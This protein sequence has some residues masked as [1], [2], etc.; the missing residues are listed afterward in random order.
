MPT[1]RWEIFSGNVFLALRYSEEAA[2]RTVLDFSM[3]W[4]GVSHRKV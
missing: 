2:L 4:Y 1:E 3:C